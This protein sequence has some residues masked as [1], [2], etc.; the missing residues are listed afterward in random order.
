MTILA[1]G[2]LL[3][4]GWIIVQWWWLLVLT[5]AITVPLLLFFRDPEREVPS[6]RGVIVS[7]G[8]GKITS[9]HNVEHHEKLGGPAVCIRMFI[10]LL[11]GHVQRS[12]CHGTITHMS[13]HPGLHGNL[14]NPDCLEGNES[15]WMVLEHPIRR[16]PIVAM[17]Q[18]AGMIARTICCVVSEGQTV[19]RG[20]RIGIIKLGSAVEMYLP[21]SLHPQVTVAV[22]A[23]VY[24]GR[25][26]LARITSP[27]SVTPSAPEQ[28]GAQADA[29][30]VD[31]PATP[32]AKEAV[33]EAATIFDT[34]D[35]EPVT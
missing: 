30:P 4:A 29:E 26:V 1:I 27:E 8:D 3:C 21:Q 2:V 10:S 15:L 23:K 32:C 34:V 24:G 12:P 28:T 18:I 13:H 35:D 6:Q 9:I 5:V 20:Q 19:Q 11:D 16:Y 25:S 7:P 31:L 17:R 14:L 22:G 33:R